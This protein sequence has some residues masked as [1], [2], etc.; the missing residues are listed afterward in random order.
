MVTNRVAT[1]AKKRFSQIKIISAHGGGT[2]PFL[3][4]RIQTIEHTF[5]V[6]PGLLELS[7]GEVREEIA[8]FHYDLTAAT[9]CTRSL[10]SGS[11]HDGFVMSPADSRCGD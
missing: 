5:G 1:G 9:S 2:I 7:S 10:L 8:S 6:G 4:N 11:G 3:V